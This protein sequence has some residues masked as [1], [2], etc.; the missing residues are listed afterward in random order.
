MDTVAMNDPKWG[1]IRMFRA[2]EMA[3]WVKEGTC[4][5]DGPSS[6]LGPIW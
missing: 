4:L 2:R 6:I 3:Q 1:R 5:P